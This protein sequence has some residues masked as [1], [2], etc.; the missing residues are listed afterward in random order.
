MKK[1]VQ[2]FQLS[3][4][5]HKHTGAKTL[6]NTGHDFKTENFIL[7]S[8]KQIRT[9]SRQQGNAYKWFSC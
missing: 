2:T 5:S 1:K 3:K 6:D 4:F 8:Q 7:K 9:K